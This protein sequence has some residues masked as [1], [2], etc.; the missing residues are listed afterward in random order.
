VSSSAV[1]MLPADDLKR[2]VQDAVTDALAADRP[3]A[4]LTKAELAGALRCSARHVD[5]LRAEG[6]PCVML[7]QESPR[8][9]LAAVLEWL[10]S[11]GQP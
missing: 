5:H 6:L 4:V 2:L 11:R 7:G 9:E 8:F 10:R 3:P 1:V